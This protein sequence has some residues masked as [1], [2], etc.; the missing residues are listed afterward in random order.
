MIDI[1]EVEAFLA[2]ADELHFGK[3]AARLHL[4]PS[5]ISQLIRR[6]ENRVGTPVLERTT[7][8]VVLTP[9]GER[10]RQDLLQVY[11][12]LGAALRRAQ[13]AGQGLEG[14]V[15]V[16]YL[17]HCGD[18]GF[19]RLTAEFRRNFPACEVSTLDVTG[20]DFFEAL[21]DDIV[22]MLLG[23][24]AAALP[25]DLV[26]G[27]VMSRE[28]WVLAVARTHPL[29][30][31][32]VISVEELGAHAIFGV[33]DPLTGD[34]HNPLYPEKTPNGV[35]IARRGVARTLAEV[36]RLVARQENVFPTSA[37]FAIYYGH[38][39]V[40]FIP[41]HGWPPATRTLVWRRYGNNPLV[42]AFIGLATDPPPKPSAKPGWTDWPGPRQLDPR[43][44]HGPTAR[45][46]HGP[47]VL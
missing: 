32:D 44:G 28:E 23:R 18:D 9:V 45:T 47:D 17:T 19:E 10:L 6:L 20:A 39:D 24:F 12:D 27:P 40:V 7:R 38:P 33:P 11:A 15:R 34:L 30:E 25:D 8:R 5:R 43:P 1:G 4:S 29:A 14:T 35:P 42:R 37:S 21:R 22:D 31:H 3:A 36:L 41:L 16:G 2:V 26:Q 13:A 46:G